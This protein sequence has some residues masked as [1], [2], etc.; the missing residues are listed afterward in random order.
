MN[1]NNLIQGNYMNRLVDFKSRF[2]I[3][4]G[5]KISLVVSAFLGSAVIASAAPSGGTVTSGTANISQSG[6]VTNIEQ[7]T[8]KASINWNDFSIKS[9]ETVN[10]NQPNSNSI[11]L[12]RVIGNEKSIID[13]ALKRKCTSVACKLKWSFVW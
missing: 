1:Q 7:S 11:T 12:N 10:F 5:G 6:N 2:R 9:N 8:S 3:L 13:G 4:K